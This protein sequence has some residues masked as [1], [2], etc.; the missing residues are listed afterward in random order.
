MYESFYNLDDKP[1]EQKADARFFFKSEAHKHALANV[2]FGFHQREGM[3]VITGAP[4]IGKTEVMHNLVSSLPREK[5]VYSQIIT[6][7]L[8]A[9]DVLNLIAVSFG[10]SSDGDDIDSIRKAV[11]EF[12]LSQVV[13]ALVEL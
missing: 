3:V 2:R 6:T 13:Q 8:V 10:I 7:N 12:F 1:F 11:E 5:Y 9:D 4:G